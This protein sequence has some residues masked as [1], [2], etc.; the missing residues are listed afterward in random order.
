MAE[1][2]YGTTPE[3]ELGFVK[4][5]CGWVYSGAKSDWWPPSLFKVS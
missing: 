3:S 4:I 1:R 5:F 2:N